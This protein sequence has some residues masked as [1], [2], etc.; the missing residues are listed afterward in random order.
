MSVIR[1]P[2]PRRTV[3]R[4]VAGVAVGLP[5]LEAMAPVT[6]KQARAAAF[7]APKRLVIWHEGCGTHI[8]S[9]LPTGGE[10]DFEL[11]PILKPLERHKKDLI[12]LQGLR[13]AHMHGHGWMPSILTARPTVGKNDVGGPSIDQH[14]VKSLGL[15]EKTKIP[16]LQLGVNDYLGETLNFAGPGQGLPAQSNPY[17]V[18]KQIF[19][20]L[21][22]L[23]DG[24]ANRLRAVRRSILDSVRQNAGTF[25][26][27]LGTADRKKLDGHLEAVR[28]IEKT[29]DDTKTA[30]GATC[31]TPDMGMQIKWD[32]DNNAP[33]LGKLQMDLL[34]MA[35]ACD[36]TR[37]I[38]LKWNSG[39]G[40]V[41]NPRK[42]RTHRWIPGGEGGWH[43]VS[44]AWMGSAEKIT[45]I[46]TWYNEQLAYMVD[47]M[48]AV[49][50]AGRRLL[51]N[52]T[53]F[54]GNEHGP[55]T[56]DW[57]SSHYALCMPYLL[58]GSCGGYFKTGR[59]LLYGDSA[60][61]PFAKVSGGGFGTYTGGPMAGKRPE[62]ETVHWGTY[63]RPW[64]NQLFV[65][66][67][68]AMGVAGDTFGVPI[69]RGTEQQV[70]PPTMNT[71]PL[72]RLRG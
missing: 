38:T 25:S 50:E 2:Q 37:V 11:S 6:R 58:V 35:L 24:Q 59:N 21:A 7:E 32:D 52:L 18:F 3:L 70:V 51:D 8:P 1:K 72:A 27:K 43:G 60:K 62:G 66:L 65:S 53:I 44:H 46:E 55:G 14:I 39:G 12:V 67:M 26:M 13:G 16:S 28:Q 22:G 49:S 10:T 69:M 64:N 20:E 15:A 40:G 31:K 4:G 41:S 45:R 48:V 36:V 63:D 30:P 71:G 34:V 23:D 47:K 17:A 29:I 5:W 54:C 9:W 56:E 33:M 19:G 57:V 68:N 61:L 42:D